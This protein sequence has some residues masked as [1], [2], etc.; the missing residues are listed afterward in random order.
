MCSDNFF[1]VARAQSCSTAAFGECGDSYSGRRAAVGR[2]LLR[3]VGELRD[4]KRRG[5][6][7]MMSDG[8]RCRVGSVR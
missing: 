3:S 1:V 7:P 5:W 4:V 8:T 2:V 6:S